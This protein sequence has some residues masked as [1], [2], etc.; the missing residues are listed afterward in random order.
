[1]MADHQRDLPDACPIQQVSANGGEC[2]T[3][4]SLNGWQWIKLGQVSKHAEPFH[5]L[6][7]L[8]KVK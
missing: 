5:G 2:R 6:G 8:R 1:M 3:G 4:A 7:P